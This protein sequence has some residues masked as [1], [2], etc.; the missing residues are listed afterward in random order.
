MAPS[1]LSR[2]YRAAGEF[3]RKFAQ[4]QSEGSPSTPRALHVGIVQLGA[5]GERSSRPAELHRQCSVL[6]RPSESV[7]SWEAA[8]AAAACQP[9]R[10]RPRPAAVRTRASILEE[11][12]CAG[13]HPH[14]IR[15]IQVRAGTSLTKHCCLLGSES[16]SRNYWDLTSQKSDDKSDSDPVLSVYARQ[17]SWDS[18]PFDFDLNISTKIWLPLF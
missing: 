10:S 4:P 13:S 14:R 3:A 16:Q 2:L 7:D 17:D 1:P 9:R 5:A 6:C 11:R 12:I 15:A 8:A 18:L